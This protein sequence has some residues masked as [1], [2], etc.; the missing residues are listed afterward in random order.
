MR[1]LDTFSTGH[2]SNVDS[3][4]DITAARKVLGFERTIESMPGHPP[5]NILYVR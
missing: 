4:A 1:V 3:T 2:H 5:A